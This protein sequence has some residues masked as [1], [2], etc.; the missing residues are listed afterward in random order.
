M[1]KDYI[2]AKSYVLGLILFFVGVFSYAITRHYPVFGGISVF[3]IVVG[4]FICAL[5]FRSMIRIF[6]SELLSIPGGPEILR[7]FRR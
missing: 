7:R 4:F 6:E 1:D 2:I 3:F 5:L